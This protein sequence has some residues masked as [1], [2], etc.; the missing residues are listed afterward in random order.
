MMIKY[1]KKNY[2]SVKYMIKL[3]I[4]QYQIA[5]FRKKLLELKTGAIPDNT[6]EIRLFMVVRNEE[7]LLPYFL[8]F[9]RGQG[10]DRFFII[11]NDSTDNTVPLLLSESNVHL[12]QTGESFQKAQAGTIWIKYLLQ[13]YGK[14]HWCVYADAD[15]FFIYPEYETTTMKTLCR[16]L[17]KKKATGVYSQLL[18]MYSMYP[19]KDSHYKSGEDP[20]KILNYFDRDV[21]HSTGKNSDVQN[22]KGN[23][24]KRIFPDLNSPSLLKVN[25][26]KFNRNYFISPGHHLIRGLKYPDIEGKTLHFKYS[27]NFISHAKEEAAREEYYNDSIE[28]KSY[29]KK[30]NE[31]PNL[32]LYSE[33][34]S[35]KF[36]NSKQ[37]V[38]LG[39][40]RSTKSYE[41]F[42]RYN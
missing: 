26:F 36:K 39:L 16:F 31:T 5:A 25:L 42:I 17:D 29:V 12:F 35:L 24:R 34:Y 32:N 40:L 3:M 18:D 9:Y 23:M 14:N 7:K 33:T 6:D 41:D 37:L 13:K 22:Y 8:K 28:Y 38:E 21:H 15:E 27:S 1:F 4:Q 2:V 11:D 20:K 10:I 30:I 19:I